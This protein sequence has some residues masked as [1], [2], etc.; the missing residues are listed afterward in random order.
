MKQPPDDRQKNF[1]ASKF[2]GDGFMGS[3]Q[4]PLDEIIADDERTIEQ[5]AFSRDALAAALETAYMKTRNALGA[6]VAIAPDVTGTFEESRGRIP[7]PFRGCGVF[8]K[9]E[10]IISSSEAPVPLII[11]SLGIHLIKNHGFFQGRGSRFRIDPVEAAKI[12]GVIQA[13][14]K[15]R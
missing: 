7:C 4:R 1:A 13:G 9:G 14:F 2:S 3:D 5:T 12:L 6:V 10:A 15:E 8:E 11:T